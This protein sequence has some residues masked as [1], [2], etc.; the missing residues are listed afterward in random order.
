MTR[1]QLFKSY[2]IKTVASTL[3]PEPLSSVQNYVKSVMI[4]GLKSN[5]DFVYIG[6]QGNEVIAISPGKSVCINGDALDYGSFAMIDL[7]TIYVK[8]DVGGE[9]VS[10]VILEGI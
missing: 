4:Q 5:T 7:S 8:V 10:Y 6:S 1:V 9:G 3:T 2:P